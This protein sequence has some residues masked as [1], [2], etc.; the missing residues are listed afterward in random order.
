MQHAIHA[1]KLLQHICR[2]QHDDYL[3]DTVIVTDDGQLSA[4]SVILA[5][6]SPVFKAALKMTDGPREHV[7]VIPRVKCSV[8]KTILQ[9]V[10]TGEVVPVPKDMANIL[11]VMLELQ[12]VCLPVSYTHLTLPT[13]RIV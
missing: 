2:Y 1:Q 8:M 12:L 10:Y 5:A 4:H 11:P 3:C 6:A 9:F 7:V 13:K